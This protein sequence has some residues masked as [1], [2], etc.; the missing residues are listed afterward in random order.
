MIYQGFGIGGLS[1]SFISGMLGGFAPTFNFIAVICVL[2]AVTALLLHVP[3]TKKV[4]LFSTREVQERSG[5][6]D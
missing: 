5:S 3:G 2:A 1:V 6:G 4:H